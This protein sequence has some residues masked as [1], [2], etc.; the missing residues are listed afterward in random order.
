MQNKLKIVSFLFVFAYKVH[1]NT[2]QG[3]MRNKSVSYGQEPMML[4]ITKIGSWR[5]R[6]VNMYIMSSFIWS[7]I[8]NLANP[9][10]DN[11]FMK[12]KH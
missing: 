7:H 12:T 10:H 1:K 8:V 11:K 5:N 4:F 9:T 2:D 6:R 3:A